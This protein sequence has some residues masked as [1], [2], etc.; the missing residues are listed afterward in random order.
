[1]SQEEQEQ[2]QESPPNFDLQ[3]RST[4]FYLE[5]VKGWVSGMFLEGIS[6]VSGRCPEC[7]IQQLCWFSKTISGSKIFG[8]QI[9]L[10]PKICWIKKK[11]TFFRHPHF[12]GTQFF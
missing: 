9:F 7:A 5:R 4:G 11:G 6:R 12:Y 3:K 2:E 8:T 10:G 1:M